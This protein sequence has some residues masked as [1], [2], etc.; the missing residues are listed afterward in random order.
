MSV[1]LRVVR[2]VE[3]YDNLKNIRSLVTWWSE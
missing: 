1:L 3:E 2:A